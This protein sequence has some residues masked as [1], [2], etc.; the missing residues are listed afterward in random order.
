MGWTSGNESAM[1]GEGRHGLHV[2][3]E[4]SAGE[5]HPSFGMVCRKEEYGGEM[6]KE[7]KIHGSSS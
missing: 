3:R 4:E 5:H 6:H 2:F 1:E 7:R